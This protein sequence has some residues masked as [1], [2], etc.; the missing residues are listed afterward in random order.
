MYQAGKIDSYYV[1]ENDTKHAE[2]FRFN[3]SDEYYSNTSKLMEL[4][5]QEYKK[6][7]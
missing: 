5:L 1:Y 6:R 4:G 2:E 7:N 3:S